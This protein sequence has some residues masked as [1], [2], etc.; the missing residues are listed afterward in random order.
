MVVGEAMAPVTI[1]VAAGI[2]GALALSRLSST[3]LYGV[4]GVDA[5][6][7]ALAAA[8][9]LA[10]ALVAA[11]IPARRAARVEPLTALRYE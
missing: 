9:M 4:A 11:A 8:L 2:A 5:L 6:S 7:I 1:G 3:L 10:V